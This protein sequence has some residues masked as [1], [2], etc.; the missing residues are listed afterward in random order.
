MGNTGD[1]KGD[2]AARKNARWSPHFAVSFLTIPKS[3]YQTKNCIKKFRMLPY[4]S[5]I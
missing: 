1:R 5:W 2:R 4:T 3:K